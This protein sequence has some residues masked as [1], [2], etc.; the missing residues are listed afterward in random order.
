MVLLLASLSVVGLAGA[1]GVGTLYLEQTKS[2]DVG[3]IGVA[4]LYMDNTWQP[5]ADDV[6]VTVNWD[7]AVL[8]YISTDWKVGNSVSATLNGT[9]SLFMQMADFTNKYGNGKVAI[10]D[11]NFKALTAG[12]STLTPVIGHVRSHEGTSSNFTD[13]TPSAIANQGTFTVAP[14]TLTPTV[15]TIVPTGNVTTVVPTGNVTTAV[16]TGNVTTARS[17]GRAHG[18]SDWEP[19]GDPEAGRH[20]LHRRVWS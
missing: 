12:S 10:A 19:E 14:G 17:D 16:P 8:G 15:T 6:W 3:Q 1:A 2:A 7:G 13:L 4:T 5:A 18:R 20:R 11:I 9:N